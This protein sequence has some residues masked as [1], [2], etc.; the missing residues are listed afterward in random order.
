MLISRPVTVKSRVTQSLRAHLGAQTQKAIREID[1]EISRIEAKIEGR[2]SLGKQQEM[3]QLEKQ[4]QEL[5]SRREGLVSKLR[6]IARLKDGQEIVSGQVQGF[7]DVKIGD[8]WSE[9][10]ACEIVLEDG[11]VVA[12][13]EGQSV[14]LAMS[15][16]EKPTNE[17]DE[18]Q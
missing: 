6:E 11:K 1:Q 13:R 12:I 3:L 4:R 9:I 16:G 15:L 5:S 8:V 10:Q 17:S 7:Y 2:K 18:K 14:T